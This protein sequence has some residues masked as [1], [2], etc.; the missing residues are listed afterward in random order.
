MSQFKI[1]IE[2]NIVAF[3][4]DETQMAKE[5]IKGEPLCCPSGTHS[6]E[7]SCLLFP[8]FHCQAE[9]SACLPAESYQQQEHPTNSQHNQM[10]KGQHKN[11]TRKSQGNMAPPGPSYPTTAS[12]GY[13]NTAKAQKDDCEPNLI[14]MTEAFKEEMSKSLKG[15]QGNTIKQEMSKT[16][17][18]MEM[19][20]EAT[21]ETQTDR[22]L[23]MENLGKRTATTK[24]SITSRVQEREE[25]SQV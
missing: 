22:I 21:K 15:I 20:I 4:N 24:A 10:A 8:E 19:G 11:T 17:Q 6:A 7:V 1:W 3:S 25:E 5:H 2:L 12:P 13:L 9:G 14:K 18:D 16:I 23:E